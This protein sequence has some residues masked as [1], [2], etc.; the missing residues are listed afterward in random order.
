MLYSKHPLVPHGIA[1]GKATHTLCVAIDVTDVAI[2]VT[3][4]AVS[5]LHIC[6]LHVPS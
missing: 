4:V 5:S 2:A 6:G 3:D 1:S